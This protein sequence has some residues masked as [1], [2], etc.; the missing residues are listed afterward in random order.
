MLSDDEL[1]VRMRTRLHDEVAGVTAAP[2]LTSTLRRRARRVTAARTSLV[3]GLAVVALASGVVVAQS[4]AVPEPGVG[5]SSAVPVYDVAHV[6]AQTEGA[7]VKAT[8]FVLKTEYTIQSTGYAYLKLVDLRTQ[9]ARLENIGPDGSAS[10]MA[11]TPVPGASP[12]TW[13]VLVV[14]HPHRAWWRH[15]LEPPTMPDG[16]PVTPATPWHYDPAQ[17]RDAMN[18]GE[19]TLVGREQV[20]GRDA[21]HLR[22]DVYRLGE[23]HSTL[24]MWVDPETYLP[25][26]IVST[27][28]L[29][30]LNPVTTTDLTWLPRT[31]ENLALL[32][33]EVPDGYT[34][35]DR[36]IVPEPGQPVG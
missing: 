29:P 3:T 16:T 13:D 27:D 7:L 36:P 2:D 23:R 20:D 30:K 34:Y 15:T 19:L 10:S 18:S 6:A 5:P 25:M 12:G 1:G 4:G 11:I 8:D 22:T 14:D 24:D 21:W 17:I 26:R 9:R 31:D 35:H 33:V 28:L 32:D